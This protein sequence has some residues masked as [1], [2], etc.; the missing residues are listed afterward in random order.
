LAWDGK[1]MVFNLENVPDDIL[2]LLV[3]WRN[4]RVEQEEAEY[5]KRMQQHR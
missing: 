2:K 4:Q 1:G 3:G 5:K